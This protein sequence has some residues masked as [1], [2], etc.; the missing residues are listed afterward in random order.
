MRSV[1]DSYTNF[2]ALNS[3]LWPNP[4]LH[5]TEQISTT[6]VFVLT[7]IIISVCLDRKATFE[8]GNEQYFCHYTEND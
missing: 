3:Q 1:K 7:K 6:E 5:L 4:G 8:E 2:L